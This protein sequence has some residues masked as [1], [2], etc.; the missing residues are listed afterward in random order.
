MASDNGPDTPADTQGV[1]C[2]IVIPAYFGAGTIGAALRSVGR[3]TGHRRCEIIV[4]ESSGDATADIVRC[5][6]PHVT[7]IRSET[8]LSAGAARNRG[9]AESRGPVVFFTDQD[10]VVPPDWLDRLERHFDDSSVGAAGG[11]VGIGNP[12]NLSGC[13]VYFLEFLY[14]FPQDGGPEHNGNFLVGCNCAFRRQVL[15]RV[16]F[17]DQTLGED[18]LFSH[19]LRQ[20]QVR[21]VYDPRI[22]VQHT[23]RRGWKEFFRYNRRMGQA[24]AVYHDA[25]QFWWIKPFF[26]APLLAFLAPVVILPSIGLSLLRSRWSYLWRFLLLLPLCLLGNLAWAAAFRRQVLAMRAEE[27]CPQD[28][29]AA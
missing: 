7:L 9:A 20:K 6:F 1:D 16:A 14:H 26:E 23:N 28:N 15:R 19:E 8:R 24:A 17:P 11:A 13:G 25:L 21:V 18:V 5:R 29:S 2:S 12:A 3:A 22:V 27:A 10:C 4:V